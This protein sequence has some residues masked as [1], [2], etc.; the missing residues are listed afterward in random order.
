MVEK[1]VKEPEPKVWKPKE[2]EAYY[3][4]SI[5]GN[6]L[7]T[8]WQND[9]F[10][11]GIYT[12]GNCFRTMEDAE[13]ALEKQKIHTELKRFAQEH[14]ETEIDWNDEGQRKYLLYYDYSCDCNHCNDIKINYYYTMKCSNTVF[15]T[16]REIAEQAIE[17]IGADRL[18]KY[19]FKVE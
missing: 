14:N 8:I 16:S 19:Y 13:F 7:N 4:I 17:E 18:K 3:Y 1:S 12:I 6:I 2:N 9:G 15:F 5:V 11:D 10:D